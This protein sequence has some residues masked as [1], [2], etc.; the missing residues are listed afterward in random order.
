VGRTST[1]SVVLSSICIILVN[2]VL[3]KLIFF[4]FP[5]RG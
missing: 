4:M 1:S 3:V 2:V 5:V